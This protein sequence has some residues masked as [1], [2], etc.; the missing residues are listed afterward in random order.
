MARPDPRLCIASP[1][2]TGDEFKTTVLPL[3]A[4]RV[5]RISLAQVRI[6]PISLLHQTEG[7]LEEEEKF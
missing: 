5:L 4:S 1:A 6:R 2:H 3:G 7:R